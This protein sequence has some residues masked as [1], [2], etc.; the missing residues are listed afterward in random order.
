MASVTFLGKVLPDEIVVILIIQI[1]ILP[2]VQLIQK[3]KATDVNRTEGLD[4][5]Y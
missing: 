3:T 2:S 5:A 4:I 1:Q